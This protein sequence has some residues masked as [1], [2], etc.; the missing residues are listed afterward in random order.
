MHIKQNQLSFKVMCSM[1]FINT[2][3]CF[4]IVLNQFKQ[5]I[6]PTTV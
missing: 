1:L 2:V 6:K 4:Q 5:V 3:Y